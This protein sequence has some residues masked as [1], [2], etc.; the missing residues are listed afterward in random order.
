MKEGGSLWSPTGASGHDHRGQGSV[1]T[2]E[3]APE[4]GQMVQPIAWRRKCCKVSRKLCTRLLTGSAS[5]SEESVV[6]WGR[7]NVHAS[8]SSENLTPSLRRAF[9]GFVRSHC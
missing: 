3:D 1:G 9:V 7:G 5:V 8:C 2:R 6:L 4:Q